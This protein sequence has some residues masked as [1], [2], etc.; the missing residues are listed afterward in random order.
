M[1][2]FV[3]FYNAYIQLCQHHL[4][5][6]FF[7]HGIIFGSL[8]SIKYVNLCVGLLLESIDQCVCF[9]ANAV[10]FPYYSSLL[11]I[12]IKDGDTSSVVQDCFHYPILF[13]SM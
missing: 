12:E 11:E 13:F 7:F 1:D 5:K 2:L 10:F 9:Y 6:R 8:S 4:L 3:F